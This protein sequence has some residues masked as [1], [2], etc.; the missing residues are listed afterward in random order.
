MVFQYNNIYY[1]FVPIFYYL[2]WSCNRDKVFLDH[3]VSGYRMNEQ[4][5]KRVKSKY[6]SV[7]APSQTFCH[8]RSI[9]ALNVIWINIFFVF[10]Q[11]MIGVTRRRSTAF[12]KYIRILYR[13]RKWTTLFS[14]KHN[15]VV[16]FQLLSSQSLTMTLL[17]C[18]SSVR[19]YRL[20]TQQ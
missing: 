9:K 16:S 14:Y 3:T 6:Q 2:L 5:Y 12:G 4:A 20:N 13:K 7:T 18:T 11:I 19:V 1:W 8:F 17:T 10:R 15:P